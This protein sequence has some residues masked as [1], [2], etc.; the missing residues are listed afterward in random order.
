MQKRGGEG[1]C[2]AQLGKD[3]GPDRRHQYRTDPADRNRRGR[4]H[5]GGR[6]AGT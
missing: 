2:L 1:L 4:A 5:D 3:D 6:E